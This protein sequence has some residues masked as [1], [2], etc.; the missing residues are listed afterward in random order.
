MARN[1]QNCLLDP[2]QSV[3][4]IID[5]EPQMFFGVESHERITVQNSV[6]GLAKAAKLFKV[7]CILTTVAADYFS[8]PMYSALTDVYPDVKPI[9]RTSI[10]SWEDANLKKAVE[11]TGKKKL[12]LAGLWTEACI[13]FP[14]LS[15]LSEGYDVYVVTDA[16]GGASKEA[17]DMAVL[18]M[19]QAGVKMVTWL[20][21]MLEFQ[22]DWNNTDTYNGVMEIVKQHAGAYGLGVAYAEAM[23]EAY[24]K[25]Q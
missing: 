24:Q 9:D 19:N 22:R 5:E 13:L 6:V 1:F 8:G 23:V 2:S 10:N 17:H 7:P 14:A 25:H 21:V 15:A 3:I 12:V 16:C 20:Q 11:K 18:R 4:V